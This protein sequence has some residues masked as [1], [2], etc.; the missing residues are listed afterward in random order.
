MKRNSDDYYEIL[1]VDKNADKEAIKKAYRKKAMQYHPDKNP[2]DKKAEEIFKKVSEAYEILSDPD[3]KQQYDNGG[4][5]NSFFA[6]PQDIF[7]NFFGGQGLGGQ[8]FGGRGFNFS[9]DNSSFGRMSRIPADTKVVYRTSLKEIIAGGQAEIQIQRQKACDKC[10]GAGHKKSNEK[11]KTCNGQGMRTMVSGNMVMNSTCNICHGSG[12]KVENCSHCRGTGN[13]TVIETISFSIP[14]GIAPLTTLRLQGKGNEIFISEQN[15]TTGDAYIVID[16]PTTFKGVS[17]K[18]GDIYAT[19]KIPFTSALNED[20]ITVNILGCKDIKLKLKSHYLSGHSY[21]VEH[22]GIKQHNDAFIKVFID[23]P[24]NKISEEN[25][26]KLI[27]LTREIYGKP[28][29][30]FQPEP[31]SADNSGGS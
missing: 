17:V 23:F 4:D 24:K 18:N 31:T 14:A 2:G 3:K 10:F 16:Y 30:K 22:E 6:N 28:D 20:E 21:K 11:C 1:G 27:N 13:N 19:I 9:F 29:T 26:E 7:A 5:L 25:R 12:K 8:G 15:K